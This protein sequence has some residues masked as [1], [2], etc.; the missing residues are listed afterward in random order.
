MTYSKSFSNRAATATS[1][2]TYIM[3]FATPSAAKREENAVYFE[4]KEA[5]CRKNGKY[6]IIKLRPVLFY[7]RNSGAALGDCRREGRTM[8]IVSHEVAFA[9]EVSSR[10]AFMHR[11]VIEEERPAPEFFTSPL[12]SRLR[13]FLA[14]H[15]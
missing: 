10:A 14:S 4:E 11:G 15:R 3:L 12:S 9:R 7:L 13:G 6:L 1:A 2:I 5:R 8:V